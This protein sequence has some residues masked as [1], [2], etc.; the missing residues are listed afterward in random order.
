MTSLLVALA[1]ALGIGSGVGL[2]KVR[3]RGP[4]NVVNGMLLPHP[5]DER[6]KVLDVKFNCGDRR[7]P[8]HTVYMLGDVRVIEGCKADI[9]NVVITDGRRYREAVVQA[10][11]ER[12]ALAAALGDS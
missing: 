7:H 2:T 11:M 3:R 6:W 9:D 12:K 8:Y 1:F 4:V 10:Q 5:S